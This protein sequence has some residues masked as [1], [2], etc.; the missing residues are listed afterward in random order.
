MAALFLVASTAT[1]IFYSFFIVRDV[2]II[3][4]SLEVGNKIL[5]NVDGDAIHFGGTTPGGS[6]KRT[7]H[8]AHEFRFPLEVIINLD[9]PLSEW[10]S[11]SDNRF[12][13]KEGEFKTVSV[14]AKV[15][16]DAAFGKYHGKVRLVFKRALI[17]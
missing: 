4:M 10:V 12:I 8:L 3:E 9:G 11:V 2:K 16:E 13:L 6:A 1:L 17:L 15:P 7:V 14:T 5:F